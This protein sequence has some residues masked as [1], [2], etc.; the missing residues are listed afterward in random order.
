MMR[1][2]SF[3][4]LKFLVFT[5]VTLAGV[6]PI[7]K[8]RYG[9][10]LRGYDAVAYHTMQKAVRGE[11]AYAY[12]WMGA[13]WYFSTNEHRELFAKNPEHYAPR[14]GG[15]CAWAVGHDY[16]A[17]GDP[18]AWSIVDGKLY[19]NYSTEV[20]SLWLKEI[21]QLIEKGSEHWPSLLSR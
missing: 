12:E 4:A 8:D 10:A 13:Q 1:I 6:D 11:M 5:T 2:S 19:L 9:V 18:L 3:I 17:E 7:D 21:P 14:F 16:I 20:R 15:Y